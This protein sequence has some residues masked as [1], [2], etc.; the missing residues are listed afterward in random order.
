MTIS[1][2]DSA[3]NQR[4]VVDEGYDYHSD[5]AYE[6]RESLNLDV[7]C[8]VSVGR[9]KQRH[10]AHQIHPENAKENDRINSLQL[11]VVSN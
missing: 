2:T 3:K 6:R 7:P 5:K 4:V 11:F 9:S 10:N 1:T 8:S